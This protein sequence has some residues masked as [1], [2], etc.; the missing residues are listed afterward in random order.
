MFK[1]N[2]SY[3]YII[4]KLIYNKKYREKFIECRSHENINDDFS[5][6]NIEQLTSVSSKVCKDLLHGHL[7]S[8]LLYTFPVT[9]SYFKNFLS[10]NEIDLVYTFMESPYFFECRT[11]PNI[12]GMGIEE[13]FYKF[14]T[15]SEYRND[16]NLME[17]SQHEFFTII[18]K[19]IAKINYNIDFSSFLELKRKNNC[20]WIIGSY[21]I[22]SILNTLFRVPDKYISTQK[23]IKIIYGKTKLGFISGLITDSIQDEIN[24][25]ENNSI[26]NINYLSKLGL[27]DKT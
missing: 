2:D 26:K 3:E 17:L 23:S 4:Y 18:F 19:L 7:K 25:Y 10:I 14:L 21:K 8:G 5:V 27:Y 20:A 13:S 1:N 24:D 15:Q 16:I 6:I 11:V 22:D 9:F 12:L